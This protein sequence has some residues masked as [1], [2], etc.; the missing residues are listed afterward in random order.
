MSSLGIYHLHQDTLSDHRQVFWLVLRSTGRTFPEALVNQLHLSGYLATVVS[1][2]SG[3]SAPDSH[4][5]PYHLL[6]RSTP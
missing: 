1:T 5:L 6:R 3:G 4:R 2:H